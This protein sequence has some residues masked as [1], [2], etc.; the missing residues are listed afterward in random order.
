MNGWLK[1]RPNKGNIGQAHRRW[2]VLESPTL[3]WYTS[4]LEH[5][6]KGFGTLTKYSSVAQLESGGQLG[7]NFEV[8][9]NSEQIFVAEAASSEQATEWVLCIN[10]CIQR[11]K[12]GAA[13]AASSPSPSSSSSSSSMGSLSASEMEQKLMEQAIAETRRMEQMQAQHRLRQESSAKSQAERDALENAARQ[14]QETAQSA[15]GRLSV[16]TARCLAVS[17]SFPPAVCHFLRA[18]LQDRGLCCAVVLCCA[19]LQ[20]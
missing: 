16:T 15:A 12:H 2:F 11:L 8:T 14:A 18:L 4:E 5:D 7:P 9:V 17:L 19:A 10:G 3:S 20:Q 13:A 1:K 6:Q